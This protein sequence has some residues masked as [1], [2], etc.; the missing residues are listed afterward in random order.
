MMFTN[1]TCHWVECGSFQL[2]CADAVVTKAITNGRGQ[3]VYLLQQ[4]GEDDW[5]YSAHTHTLQ[6]G[7][8]HGIFIISGN[9]PVQKHDLIIVNSLYRV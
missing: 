1:D 4:P 5:S 2:N 8:R 7:G 9:F 6:Q 3:L